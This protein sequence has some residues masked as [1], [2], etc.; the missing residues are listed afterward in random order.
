M[1]SQFAELDS[2]LAE[3]IAGQAVFFVGSAPLA[4]EG[5]VNVSP[6][7]LDSF[8]ILGTKQVAYLDLTGSGVEIF[9]VKS[10]HAFGHDEVS[11]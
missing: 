4:R 6:K 11:M 9:L 1:A 8:R 2:S 5:H 10:A 7:G 3:F